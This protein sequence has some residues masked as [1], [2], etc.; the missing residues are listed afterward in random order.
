MEE[1]FRVG[2]I[3]QT[4]GIAGEVKVFPT[5]EDPARFKILKECYIVPVDNPKITEMKAHISGVKFF[6]NMVILRFKEFININEIEPYVKCELWIDREQAIPLEEGQFYIADVIGFDVVDDEGN[7]IGKLTDVLDNPANDIYEITGDDGHVYLF[8]GI[9]EC[10]LGP[11][12]DNKIL[13][14]HVLDGL[15]DL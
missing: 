10:I 12:M 5:T 13:H 6:K 14:V 15:M 7:R 11:D 3:T 9:K 4:H 1:R 2:V 8:P